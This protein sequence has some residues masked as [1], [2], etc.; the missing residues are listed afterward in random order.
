MERWPW[1][2]PQKLPAWCSPWHTAT[3]TCLQRTGLV[4][5]FSNFWTPSGCTAVRE[6]CASLWRGEGP[7]RKRR[8]GEWW[9]DG[10]HPSTTGANRRD[11]GCDSRVRT[12]SCQMSVFEDL[13]CETL[14]FIF[15]SKVQILTFHAIFFRRRHITYWFLKKQQQ[16]LLCFINFSVLELVRD[17]SSSLF[18]TEGFIS[19]PSTR[20]SFWAPRWGSAW[21]GCGCFRFQQVD[22]KAMVLALHLIH[23]S[24][25]D[26]FESVR[27]GPQQNRHT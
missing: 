18:F 17:L 3:P 26:S 8:E 2:Q 6:G 16:Q 7:E 15:L 13:H 19:P 21:E 14:T 12:S 24:T 11:W 4:R 9:G 20:S 1:D 23:M 25:R 22:C 27:S 10:T 5:C